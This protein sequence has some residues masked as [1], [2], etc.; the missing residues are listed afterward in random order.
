MPYFISQLAVL[1]FFTSL[2]LRVFW[3]LNTHWLNGEVAVLKVGGGCDGGVQQ[4][5]EQSAGGRDGGPL[6]GSRL[7]SEWQRGRE[8]GGH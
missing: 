7:Q 6:K 8:G 5:D 3:H 1:F 4:G 2:K